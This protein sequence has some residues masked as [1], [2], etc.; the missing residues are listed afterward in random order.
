MKNSD[1]ITGNVR[2]TLSDVSS[3]KTPAGQIRKTNFH[4]YVSQVSEVFPYSYTYAGKSKTSTAALGHF[5][6]SGNPQHAGMPDLQ[7]KLGN[8]LV[9]QANQA[10]IGFLSEAAEAKETVEGIGKVAMR[11]YRAAKA[12]RQGQ[13]EKAL[14]LLGVNLKDKRD[15][16]KTPSDFWLA[17]QFGVKPLVSLVNELNEVKSEGFQ[18]QPTKITAKESINWTTVQYGSDGFMKIKVTSEHTHVL[19]AGAVFSFENPSDRFKNDYGFDNPVTALWQIVPYSFL[20]DYFLPV[21]DWLDVNFSY[22][23]PIFS[24][25]WKTTVT[26]T[27]V[28]VQVIGATDDAPQYRDSN[29]QILPLYSFPGGIRSKHEY[30]RYGREPYVPTFSLVANPDP[31]SLN[32]N[33]NIIAL[34]FSK[35][36]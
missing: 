2:R 7:V 14:S 20:I 35:L 18:P 11:I 23:K 33:L 26:K 21:G 5:Y 36:K 29:G 25:G 15:L 19:R 3:T 31:L 8:T 17:Y 16:L 13:F 28:T 24:L 1:V 32:Q 10:K 27:T 12:T 4:S 6:Y 34:L 9:S 30:L 22:I